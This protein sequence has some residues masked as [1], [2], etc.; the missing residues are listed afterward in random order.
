MIQKKSLGQ[1]FLTDK[2]I[3]RKIVREAGVTM[4]DDVW[5]IGPGKGILTDCLCEKCRTLTVFEIDKQW[6]DYIKVHFQEPKLTIVHADILD[7]D[8]NE[9]AHKRKIKIVA[10]LPYQIT[11][12]LLFKIIDLREIFS[13]ITIMI[14]DEVADR[15]CAV[16]GN[17][18]YGRLTVKAQLFF[19]VVKLFTV[20][21][22]VF[23]PPPKITSAVVQLEPR[24]EVYEINDLDLLWEIIDTTFIHRRKMVRKTLK[25]IINDSELD[26]L[27]KK[28]DVDLTRR[29]ES[30]SIEEF[31]ELAHQINMIKGT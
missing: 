31:L 14:Q 3:A 29:P 24:K 13:S 28:F 27:K 23:F 30:F 17:K 4:K 9:F 2:N 10:N 12:P 8:F 15:L 25:R 26:K 7:I 16:P 5:E 11:S 6:V 1:H 21:A 22:H 18:D 20:P 19:D